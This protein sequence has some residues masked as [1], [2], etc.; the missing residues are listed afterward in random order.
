MTSG[1]RFVLAA[2]VALGL[3]VSAVPAADLPPEIRRAVD[4]GVEAL[5]KMQAADGTWPHNEIGAT[6]LVGLTLLECDVPANDPAVR[7]AAEAVRRAA[8]R[9]NQTYSV[10]L[11]ILFLDRL[12]DPAD[13]VLIQALA[14]RLLAGQN[15]GGGWGYQTGNPPSD[16]E[17]RWVEEQLR[18]TDKANPEKNPD[19]KPAVPPL[20]K[21]LQLQL[22]AIQRTPFDPAGVG[23]NSNTQFALLAL[24]VAARHGV[25][26]DQAAARLDRRFR[27]TQ[28][29]DGGWNYTE[30]DPNSPSTPAMTCAALLGLAVGHGTAARGKPVRD[31]QRDPNVRMGLLALGTSIDHPVSKK[32]GNA[33]VPTVNNDRFYYFLWSLERVGMVY[34]LETIGGKDWYGWGSEILLANQKREGSWGG[35]ICGET[36]DTCFALLFLVRANPAREL[37]AMLR[38]GILDP[39]E[40]VLRNGGVDV[41]GLQKVQL[42]SALS[43]QKPSEKDKSSP[44]PPKP[45][46]VLEG[47]AGRL[48][49][50][51]LEARGPRQA[52]VLA[53]LR[54]GRG[55]VYTQALAGAIHRLDGD[56]KSKAREALAGRLTRMSSDTLTDKVED[57]DPEVRRAA[58]LALAMKDD[59]KHVGKLIALLDDPEP[60]V[61]RAA[62]AALRSLTGKD[63]GPAADA[64]RAEHAKAVAAWK[65]WWSKQ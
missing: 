35:G 23:D 64:S 17:V 31:L 10:A 7:K 56:A 48:A 39:G 49:A 11:A 57:D 1:K 21:E 41:S 29:N 4:R 43:P 52:E 63:F 30:H 33:Q 36:A 53:E 45:A 28:K 37:T 9:S 61:V 62:H 44:K 59:R 6:A 2:L 55:V 47:E 32:G 34:G 38:G 18:R 60:L 3:S 16:A 19:G 54:D 27:T 13:E 40:V 5:R 42:P 26:I 12:G 14:V 20:A 51:L 24:W 25:P 46:P 22:Q 50:R 58:A 65:A 15:G 8:L